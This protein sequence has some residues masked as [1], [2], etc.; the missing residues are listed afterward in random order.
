M[1]REQCCQK[2]KPFN[3]HWFRVIKTVGISIPYSINLQVPAVLPHVDLQTCIY[4]NNNFK[5]EIF[6]TTQ[7]IINSQW[8]GCVLNVSKCAVER[9]RERKKKSMCV[10]VAVKLWPCK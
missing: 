9:E 3:T 6:Y 10:M 1:D 5:S 2:Y 7:E 4:L 8:T